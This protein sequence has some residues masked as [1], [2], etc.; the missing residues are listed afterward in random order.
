MSRL[1]LLVAL[2]AINHL[3]FSS[4]RLAVA[5]YA[6]HLQ[7]SIAAIGVLM[8]IFGLLAALTSVSTGRW[9]DRVGPRKPMLLASAAMVAGAALAFVWRDLAA[10]YVVSAVV[11]TMFNVFFVAYQPLIGQYGRPEDRVRN[12]SIASVGISISSFIAPL[13]TGFAIDHAGYAETFLLA[14]ALPLIPLAVIGL[15]K[16]QFPAVAKRQTRPARDSA[17][18]GVFQLLRHRDL[19]RIYSLSL[20]SNV[21]WNLFSFLMPLYCLE[22]GLNAFSIGLV[23]GSYALASVVSRVLVGPLSRWFTPWQ[24]LIV[25]ACVGGICFVGFALVHTFALLLAFSFLL[26]LGFGLAN[27]MS[28]ALLYEAAPADRI[29]EV[30]GLRIMMGNGM[31]TVVP[32]V[33][34]AI[35]AAFGMGPI[36]WALAATQFFTAYAVRAQWRRRKARSR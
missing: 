20:L 36:F 28:Q 10:L 15:G 17:D 30:M 35:G 5:L 21:T 22:L 13:V 7:A 25:S 23:L 8:A 18:S 4:V 3:S 31:Q 6:V 2:T 29:G 1:Y 32:L 26:G 19:R 34:G 27:P 33:S 11:G 12:F 24:L 9:V 16:L 14:A